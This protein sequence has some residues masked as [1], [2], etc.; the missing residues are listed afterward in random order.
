MDYHAILEILGIAETS[1][2][3]IIAYIIYDWAKMKFKNKNED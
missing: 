2:S 3:P 1:A